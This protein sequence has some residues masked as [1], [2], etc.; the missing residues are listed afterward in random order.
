MFFVMKCLKVS[1]TNTVVCIS[2]RYIAYSNLTGI[3]LPCSS[4]KYECFILKKLR[5]QQFP[6]GLKEASQLEAL[7]SYTRQSDSHHY[8]YYVCYWSKT[9]VRQNLLSSI[10]IPIHIYGTLPS[11]KKKS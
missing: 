11:L 2:Q 8:I 1:F 4:H 3:S 5:N 7:M 6:E 9:V 10:P